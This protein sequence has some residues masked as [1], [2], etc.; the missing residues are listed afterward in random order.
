MLVE[1]LSPNSEAE[2]RG[3]KW[4]PYQRIPSLAHYVLVSQHRPR[5]EVYTRT[6]LGWHYAESLPGD[7]FQLAALGVAIRVD[8]LY[9]GALAAG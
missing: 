2:D 7:S 1:V 4:A 8:D 5:V 3:E 6:E 9:A